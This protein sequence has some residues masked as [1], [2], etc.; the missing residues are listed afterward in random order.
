[1][2]GER[3]SRY[4]I[5]I[6]CTSCFGGISDF[7]RIFQYPCQPQV[8]RLQF[9]GVLRDKFYDKFLPHYRCNHQ[10]PACL[11]RGPVVALG[12]SNHGGTLKTALRPSCSGRS[13]KVLGVHRGLLTH[14]VMGSEDVS[15]SRCF[16]P[17]ILSGNT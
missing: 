4:K 15:T 1:M 6:K 9:Q 16:T 11:P 5:V 10:C 8:F 17:S 12:T 14:R 2:L 13:R 7:V 3:I